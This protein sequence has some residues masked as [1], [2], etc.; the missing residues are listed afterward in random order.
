VPPPKVT[1]AVLRIE[2]LTAPRYDAQLPDLEAVTAAAFGQRRKMLR[3]SLK[4]LTPQA[5]ALLAAAEVDGT[6]RAEDLDLS[7]FCALAKAYATMRRM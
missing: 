3:G 2:P 6:G 5:E 1:S 4:S 7:Q